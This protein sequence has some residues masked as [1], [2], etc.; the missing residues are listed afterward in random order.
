MTKNIKLIVQIEL[1]DALEVPRVTIQSEYSPVCS[2]FMKSVQSTVAALA[3]KA[4]GSIEKPAETSAYVSDEVVLDEEEPAVVNGEVVSLVADI[5]E[6]EAAG[7]YA[8][9]P[10]IKNV[11]L[12][13]IGKLVFV[14]LRALASARRARFRA[15]APK[16][17]K[18]GS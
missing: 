15:Q 18:E 3:L 10:G 13:A 12:L 7:G 11:T 6:I 4:K 1:R 16:P 17:P 9:A 2:R 14:Q 8:D 5:E